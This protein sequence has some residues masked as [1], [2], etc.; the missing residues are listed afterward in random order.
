LN[1]RNVEREWKRM[2]RLLELD[3]GEMSWLELPVDGGATNADRNT[4]INNLGLPPRWR[5]QWREKNG[6]WLLPPFYTFGQPQPSAKSKLPARRGKRRQGPKV[7]VCNAV[8][9]FFIVEPTN[10][11]LA[12][13]Q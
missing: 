12:V 10:P 11:I 8:D 6:G 1:G 7:F 9:S 5:W 13:A 4:P 3:A 2:S